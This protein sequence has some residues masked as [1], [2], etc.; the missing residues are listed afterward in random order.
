MAGRP[1]AGKSTLVNALVGEKVSITSRRP[2]TTRF[3]VRG[4]LNVYDRRDGGDRDH[5]AGPGSGRLRAQVTLAD[6]PGLHKPRTALGERLNGVV[7]RTMA[8]AD[9]ALAVFDVFAGIGPGDRMVAERLRERVA[10][11][12]VV[13]A[14]NKTDKADP[15]RVAEQLSRAALWDFG[16]YVPVSAR[17]GDGLDRLTDEVVSR[18][19]EGPVFFPEGQLSD[20]PPQVMVAEI[21]R[22]KLLERLRDELP[23]SVAVT[24]HLA[25]ADPE[26]GGLLRAEAVIYVERNSQKGIVIGSGGSVL[27]EVG[28][29]VRRELEGRMGRKVFLEMRVKVERDWQSRP[30]VMR[31]LGL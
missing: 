11:E 18:M 28:I 25:E 16:A 27:K 26:A 5:R 8:E 23:H 7:Y 29:R 10:P 3:A 17:T 9:C 31:R 22:E 6:T 2:Q 13:A 19:P 21:I 12:R 24:A 1:N 4:V 15:G 14:L 30:E 20:Q